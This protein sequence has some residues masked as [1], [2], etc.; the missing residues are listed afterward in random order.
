MFDWT[1]LTIEKKGKEVRIKTC[2]IACLMAIFSISPAWAAFNKSGR[3]SLQFLKIGIGSRQVA[4]GEACVANTNDINSVFWNPAGITG[5]KG[6]ETSFNYASWIGDLNI[7]GAAI[8]YNLEGV[9]AIALN[10]VGLDYGNISEALVT[11]PTGHYDTRTG[12]NFSGSD[13]SIGMA[14]ARQFT[15]RL[16]IG[17]NI[18]YIQEEL[19]IYKTSI[20]GF[21][22]GSYY[23]TGWKGIRLAMSAQN[24]SGKARFL[25]TKEEFQQTYDL[26]LIFRLGWSIDLLGGEQLLLGGNPELHHL[27]FNMDVVHTNDYAERYHLGLEYK[28]FDQFALR[29]G[30]RFNYEEG[31]FSAGAG[32]NSKVGPMQIQIDYAY[33]DYDFLDATHR[34]SMV[35]GF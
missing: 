30:Y 13:L 24:F 35:I 17:V 6:L 15:D 12:L 3:T 19:F 32:F 16:S 2:V 1:S 4:L 27:S 29:T 21:D 8:G 31:N 10:Y 25:K 28:L 33:V 7:L 20:W 11:S 18:K 5:I 22:V 14:L 9:G 34:F 23:D 26:P